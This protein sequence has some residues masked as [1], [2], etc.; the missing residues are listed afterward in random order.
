ML[1]W[2]VAGFLFWKINEQGQ[3][4]TVSGTTP[5][6]ARHGE[7]QQDGFLLTIGIP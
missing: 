6:I 3:K 4:R 5:K 1:K 7:R 2:G